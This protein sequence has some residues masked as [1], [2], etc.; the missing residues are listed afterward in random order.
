METLVILTGMTLV[1]IDMCCVVYLVKEIKGGLEGMV[2][3]IMEQ[4]K[5]EDG[6]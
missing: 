4:L 3:G 2:K 1:L 5:E 6:K